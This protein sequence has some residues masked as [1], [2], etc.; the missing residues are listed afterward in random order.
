MKAIVKHLTTTTIIA[1]FVITLNVNANG[2]EKPITTQETIETELELDSWMINSQLWDIKATEIF[3]TEV[4]N[5]LE[6]ESWMVAD[7]TWD[8]QLIPA[9]EKENTLQLEGWM[10]NTE[11][12][13]IL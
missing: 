5:E 6:M 12:W 13:N 11:F 3:A 7:S 1:L 10:I 8:V 9:N 4:D 2:T